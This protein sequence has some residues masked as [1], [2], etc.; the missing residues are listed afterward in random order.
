MHNPDSF[1][2][3][4]VEADA[5]E[6]SQKRMKIPEGY[7]GRWRITHMEMWDQ[8]FVD[9]VVP[10]H[11]MIRKDGVGSFQFGAIQGEMDFRVERVGDQTMLGFSWDGSDE[12]DPAS[13][14]GWIQVNQKEMIG[15][16]S[17][18]LGDDSG[19]KATK[20]E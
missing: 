13:G 8:D 6:R 9:L 16:I 20:W 4:P 2:P 18:H 14:R 10:G 19:F 12:C 5:S 3:Y 7:L 15:H 1:K 17:F 11:F